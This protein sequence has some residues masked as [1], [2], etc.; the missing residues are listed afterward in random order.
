MLSHVRAMQDVIS[1]SRSGNLVNGAQRSF[2]AAHDEGYFSGEDAMHQFASGWLGKLDEETAAEALLALGTKPSSQPSAS[3][4][5][6]QIP[7]RGHKRTIS[8]TEDITQQR[9]REILNVGRDVGPQRNQENM[10]P[11]THL[12]QEGKQLQ[13]P[14]KKWAPAKQPLPVPTQ[15]KRVALSCALQKPSSASDQAAYYLRED[16]MLA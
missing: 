7:A 11:S 3:E 13:M 2:V 6:Q 15:S 8:K 5:S 14:S 12:Q 10:R 1:K 16:L 4:Q 9:V